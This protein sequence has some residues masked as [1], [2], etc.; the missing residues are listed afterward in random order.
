[1][2]CRRFIH[3]R[4]GVTFLMIAVFAMATAPVAAQ[5]VSY[6]YDG[7]YLGAAPPSPGLSDPACGALPLTQLDIRDGALRAFDGRF[8]IVK[9][10]IT[11]D[12]FFN[13][14]YYFPDGR[15]AVFE[16]TVDSDGRLLGG[17]MASG[18]VWIID[19]KKVS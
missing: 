13:A 18:C 17:V 14:D 9:G 1:M 2:T 5:M 12:G 8:Q 19:L 15:R 3:A 16:G 7:L 6:R 11:H 4:A 10:I